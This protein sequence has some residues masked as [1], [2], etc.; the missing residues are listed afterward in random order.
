MNE[1]F[2][3]AELSDPKRSKNKFLTTFPIHEIHRTVAIFIW[4]SHKALKNE[5][6]FNKDLVKTISTIIDCTI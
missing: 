1:K 6:A 3:K 2:I 4:F 5:K